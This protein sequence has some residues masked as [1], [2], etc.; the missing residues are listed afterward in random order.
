[1]NPALKGGA[2][3][4]ITAILWGGMF[5]VAKDALLV[6]DAF[7]LNTIRYGAT[8][9][10]FLAILALVEGPQAL[11]FDGRLVPA[12][13]LGTIGFGGFSLLTYV[14]L[15]YTQAAHGAIIMALQPMIAALIRWIW[16]S[17]RPPAITLA[18]IVTA[19]VGVFLVVTKGSVDEFVSG[20]GWGDSLIV[21]GAVSWV[22]YTLAA[23]SFPGWSP[24]RYTTLTCLTGELAIV[25]ITLA[26]T[27]FGLVSAPSWPQTVEIAPQMG[28]LIVFASIVSVLAWNAGIRS[29][30]PLSGMLF[31]NL[32]PIA[33]FLIGVYQGQHFAAAELIGAA[34]VMSALIVNNL[35]L[36][37]RSMKRSE[38]SL[39][40]VPAEELVPAIGERF[41]L[42]D[43]STTQ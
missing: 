5:P 27:A 33:A 25:A 31:I 36:K 40:A 7:W 15:A 8:A 14:G 4:L 18:C 12:F 39:P 3:L 1:M 42:G 35:S 10:A 24:L 32:V 16:K 23:E 13:V 43:P 30:G 38:I 29:L 41:K 19:F 17:H 34:L 22:V 37:A 11:R 20:T 6:M 2:L 28:Y 26:L 9:A 21:L